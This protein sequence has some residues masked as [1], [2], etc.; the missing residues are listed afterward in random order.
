MAMDG[1]LP[2][3]IRLL[4]N[5]WLEFLLPQSCLHCEMPKDPDVFLCD[6]CL[7]LLHLVEAEERCQK[8]FLPSKLNICLGC[9]KKTT[10]WHSAAAAFEYEG[11]AATLVKKLKYGGYKHL[12]KGIAAFMVGQLLRLE[13]PLPDVIVPVPMPLAR[14]VMRGYNQSALIAQE[15][16]AM[17]N[18][19]FLNALRKK[20]GDFSRAGLNYRQRQTFSSSAFD[21]RDNLSIE[22]CYVLLVDDV[23]TTGSTL[24]FCAEALLK[25]HPKDVY[26]LTLCRASL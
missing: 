2:S 9:S 25:G 18:R 21:F 1:K 22:D 23:F 19:S 24:H 3:G 7:E 16:A 26:A 8:C 15:I 6:T 13:W 14:R 5:A 20:S 10:L 4:C 17:L 12:A 11:P